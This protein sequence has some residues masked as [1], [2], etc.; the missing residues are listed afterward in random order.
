MAD[1]KEKDPFADLMTEENKPDSN[2]FKFEKVGDKVM[3][4]LVGVDDKEGKDPFPPQRVFTLKNKEGD[5]VKVGI[6]LK[7]DYIIGRANSAKM[8]DILGF[9]FVKEIPN[10]KKGFNPAKSIEVYVKHIE[11]A[12]GE[13]VTP[14][15]IDDF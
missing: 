14:A 7:K 13:E 8:G 15:N 6:S 9:E 3:G 2:W 1:A 4:F 11:R 5:F 10:E 12:E